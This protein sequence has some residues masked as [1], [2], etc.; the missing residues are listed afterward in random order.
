MQIP[1]ARCCG[2]GGTL[3]AGQRYHFV[4][5]WLPVADGLNLLFNPAA[6]GWSVESDAV[7]RT[8]THRS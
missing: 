6:I 5:G 3:T 4:A 8:S 7:A 2:P 1:Y